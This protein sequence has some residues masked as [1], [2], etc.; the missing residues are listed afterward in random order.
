M[1]VVIAIIG[2]LMGLTLPAIMGARARARQIECSNN[3]RNLATAAAS[4]RSSKQRFPGAQELLLPHDPASVP[5]GNP[6]YNK[7]ASWFVML[8]PGMGRNDVFDRWQ[9]TAVAAGHPILTPSLAFAKCPSASE[10]TGLPATTH[11]VANAGFIPRPS[12]G[13]PLGSV[14]YLAVSQRPANGLFLDRITNPNAA[15]RDEDVTDGASCT[16]ML[17]E[18]LAAFTWDSFGPLDPTQRTYRINRGW[19]RDLQLRYPVGGTLGDFPRGA[20]FRN[21]MVFCYAQQADGPPVSPLM[22]GAMV[23]PQSPVPSWMK[24]NGDKTRFDEGTSVQAEIAR[25]SSHHTG[26][27]LVAMADGSVHMIHDEIAY[28]VYQQLMTP[29]GRQSDMPSRLHHRL[30]ADEY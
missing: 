24:I 8:L 1:L 11:Y 17:S 25:P 5:P 23:L 22:G 7:P 28:H 9:S 12:D 14:S 19:S 16:I 2:I 18:N 30:S 4:F 21:T 27:V 13:V 20:R 26:G 29:A 6:G 10:V 3:L 15:V